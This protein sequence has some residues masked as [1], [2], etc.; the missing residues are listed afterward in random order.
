[1]ALSDISKQSADTVQSTDPVPTGFAGYKPTISSSSCLKLSLALP[2][3][4]R[5]GLILGD[6]CFSKSIF[7]RG[8]VFTFF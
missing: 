3:D 7:K 5:L 1:M 2:G 8:L 6:N 4:R